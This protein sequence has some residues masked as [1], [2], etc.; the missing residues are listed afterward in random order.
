MVMGFDQARTT[1]HFLLF[2]DGGAIEVGVND[3]A[4]TKNRDAIRSHLRYLD[5][6]PDSPDR[7][8]RIA[9]MVREKRRHLERPDSGQHDDPEG[10]A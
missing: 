3:P 10:Q 1:H 5:E 4:D 9:E 8:L 7:A 2:D 6:H